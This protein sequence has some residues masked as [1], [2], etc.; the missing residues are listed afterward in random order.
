MLQLHIAHATN[1]RIRPAKN[2]RGQC[3]INK[4][5]GNCH[6]YTYIYIHVFICIY[7]SIWKS[8]QHANAEATDHLQ[9][10]EY[11]P[12]CCKGRDCDAVLNPMCIV[13]QPHS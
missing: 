1:G 7:I 13:G 2:D 12:V 5:T 3:N 6:S 10:V 9:L 8:V 4:E 11:D